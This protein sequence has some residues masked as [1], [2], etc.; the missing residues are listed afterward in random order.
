[1]AKGTGIISQATKALC[2]MVGATSM[3]GCGSADDTT[4]TTRYEGAV[5]QTTWNERGDI[6]TVLVDATTN[7]R[8]A[9]MDWVSAERRLAWNVRDRATGAEPM[10]Q[11]PHVSDMNRAILRLHQ[12]AWADASGDV[13]PTF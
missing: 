12:A 9:T 6:H 4:L 13:H 11:P 8:V 7:N 5:A 3:I 10:P 2:V 1:M